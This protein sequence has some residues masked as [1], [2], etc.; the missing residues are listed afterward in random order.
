MMETAVKVE[1]LYAGY[2]GPDI[3]RNITLEAGAGDFL[4]IAGPNGSGK[5]TLLRAIARLIPCRGS[6]TVEGR[7]IGAL[8]RW[9]LARKIA[10]LGQ[11]SQF[12]FP[13]TVYETVA[14]GRYAYGRG[15]WPRLGKEDREIIDRTLGRLELDSLAQTPITVLSGGQ[16]QRVFLARTL[17][18]NPAIILL[19]EPTN[20]LDL[21]YQVELLRYLGNWAGEAGGIVIA[22]LHDLNLARSFA[23]RM[24]LLDKGEVKAAGAAGDVLQSPALE[25]AYGMDIPAFMRE[26]L[27]RWESL[28]V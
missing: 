20:H 22:V 2:N 6:V 12:Y 13:Y 23:G 27:K 15:F 4:C 9:E 7:D 8:K 11:T 16:L 24:I 19:D 5:S 14:L 10:L 26:A 17:V 3:I 28:T 25:A 21:K 1:A 18:Q